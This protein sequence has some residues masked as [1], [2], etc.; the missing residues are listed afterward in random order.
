[1]PVTSNTA[2]VILSGNPQ[3]LI[4]NKATAGQGLSSALDTSTS[5]SIKIPSQKM[6]TLTASLD[7]PMNA[8]TALKMKI[9]SPYRGANTHSISLE[10]TP[11]ILA[12]GIKEGFYENLLITYEYSATVAAGIVPLSCKTIILT[13]LESASSN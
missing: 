9:A 12:T 1:M 8:H 2:T 3:P 5:C 13:I 11:K 10:C 4:I 6:A 7:S